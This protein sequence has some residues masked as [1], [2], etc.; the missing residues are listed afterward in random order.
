MWV[1][2]V[3]MAKFEVATGDNLISFSSDIHIFT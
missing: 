2:K 1:L 3:V